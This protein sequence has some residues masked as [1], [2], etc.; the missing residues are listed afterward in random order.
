MKRDSQ[1]RKTQVETMSAAA[2][3]FT[4]FILLF[5]FATVPAQAQTPTVVYNFPAYGGDTCLPEGALVQGRDGNMYGTGGCSP[6]GTNVFGGV[7]KIS[8]TGVESVIAGSPTGW[9]GCNSGLT[10]GNDGNFYGTCQSGNSTNFGVI[11]RLTPGGAYTDLHDFTDVTGD[12]FPEQPP[13]QASDGNFYGTTGTPELGR[14]GTVYQLTAAGKYKTLHAFSGGDCL[15]STLT[16]ASDG[17]LYGTLRSC[18][19]TG[20][21]GCVYKISLTGVFKDIYGFP[22]ATTGSLPCT[23]VI[24]G[25]DGK[26]YGATNTGGANGTGDLYKVATAGGGHTVLHDFNNPTDASCVNNENANTVLLNLTQVTDGTIYGV[27]PA[28]GSIGNGGI[29][30]LT[31]ANVFS[32][33]LFPN[34]PVEG[35]QPA[36]TLIQNT[37]GLV[38]GTTPSGGTNSYCTPGSFCQGVLFSV[39]TGDAAFVNLEPTQK[40]GFV[41]ASVGMFGQ[42]FSGAS[43]VKF[44]GVAATSVTL[45]GTTYLTAVVPAGAHTGTVTVTTGTTTL[46]SPQTYKVKAKVL[47]FTPTSGHVGQLVTINGT[48]LIQTTGVKF[49]AVKATTFTVVSD[50]QVTAVVPTLPLGAVTISVTTPGGTATSPTKFTVN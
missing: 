8:P 5:S 28:Y 40:T 45:T 38:Y 44:G 46:T 13:I 9:A 34:P 3:A 6:G 11:Y 20:S 37:N 47:N 42:G 24:Q 23:G 43:V 17:N 4:M 26:L 33:F 21:L 35:A 10:V 41:G 36:G 22:Q 1:Q 7:Y 18:T 12:G 2:V 25:K 32:A 15:S 27:N 16:Q 31:S 49:G 29:F 39:A 48:G 14:C 50:S 30:K 19:I